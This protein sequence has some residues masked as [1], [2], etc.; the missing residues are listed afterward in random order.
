MHVDRID[1]TANRGTSAALMKRSEDSRNEGRFDSDAEPV[2]RSTSVSK[3][4]SKVSTPTIPSM[5]MIQYRANKPTTTVKG[6]LY[7][8]I[9]WFQSSITTKRYTIE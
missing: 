4:M 1:R 2:S 9:A 3:S 7:G 8:K 5:Q 6:K